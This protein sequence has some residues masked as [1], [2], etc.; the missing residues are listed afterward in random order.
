MAVP[1][2]SNTAT[3]EQASG[4]IAA[5]LDESRLSI[6]PD[7]TH[8]DVAFM[9]C[10]LIIELLAITPRVNQAF[11]EKAIEKAFPRITP[12]HRASWARSVVQCIAHCRFTSRRSTTGAKLPKCNKRIVDAMR[13][14]ARRLR[15]KTSEASSV[16]SVEEVP[17]RALTKHDSIV[18]VASDDSVHV[19]GGS[20]WA[21]VAALYGAVPGA[22]AFPAAPAT[23]PAKPATPPPLPP[24]LSDP[25]ARHPAKP[26]KSAPL[27]LPLSDAPASS[28]GSVPKPTIV[29][30]KITP[31]SAR[32]YMST[33]VMLDA[34][35]APGPRGFVV[36]TWPE[37]AGEPV[38][39][40]LDM[41]NLMLEDSVPPKKTNGR[42]PLP[43]RRRSHLR[44]SS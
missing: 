16:G 9:Y 29:L 33:G 10:D 6:P 26:A 11:L 20:Q 13:L 28:A 18:S 43:S 8:D 37:G 5:R 3:P 31:T 17:A 19:A 30:Q 40:E 36:A 39:E 22:A 42:R 32:R 38:Q 23:L 21:A 34:L 41:P 14:P 1:R 2:V 27:P 15:R 12:I 44:R 24:P 35:L 4:L 7:S 25:P